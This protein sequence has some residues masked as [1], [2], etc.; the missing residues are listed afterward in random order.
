MT[1]PLR[2]QDR[3]DGGGTGGVRPEDRQV[4][5]DHYKRMDVQPWQA[6][7]AWMPREEFLGFLRGNAIKYLARA[8][9]KGPVREDLEKARHYLDALIGEYPAEED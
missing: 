7:R 3:E 5:G 4:G 2:A 6:M 9:S 1:A 8:G